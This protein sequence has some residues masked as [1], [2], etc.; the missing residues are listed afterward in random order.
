LK[1][2]WSQLM[3]MYSV[4]GIVTRSPAVDIIRDFPENASGRQQKIGRSQPGQ[5]CYNGGP[6]HVP[7]RRD[8]Q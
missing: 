2:Q 1:F 7:W 5:A 8:G 3:L 4:H 6:V